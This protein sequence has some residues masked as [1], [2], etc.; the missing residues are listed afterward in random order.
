MCG[1]GPSPVTRMTSSPVSSG[2]VGSLRSRDRTSGRLRRTRLMRRQRAV[3]PVAPVQGD[4]L[5]EQGEGQKRDEFGVVPLILKLFREVA[6]ARQPDVVQSGGPGMEH[7]P[8]GDVPDDPF[9][10]IVCAFAR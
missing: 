6:Y 8:F 3:P 7:A 4:S 2:A 1:P 5:V 9:D 10:R